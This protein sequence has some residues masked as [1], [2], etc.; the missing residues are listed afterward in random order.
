MCVDTWEDGHGTKRLLFRA[1]GARQDTRVQGHQISETVVLPKTQHLYHFQKTT[2]RE[3]GPKPG[4]TQTRQASLGWGLWVPS[5]ILLRNL[6]SPL[7]L[8]GEHLCITKCQEPELFT[9]VI[10]MP[11]GIQERPRFFP[12]EITPRARPGQGG[13]CSVPG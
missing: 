10:F 1:I 7:S 12:S 9:W 4:N 5:L 2:S 3:E 11:V 8:P 6:C 13:A